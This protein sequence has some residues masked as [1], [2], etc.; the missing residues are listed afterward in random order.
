MGL[1]DFF[2]AK[3]GSTAEAQERALMR[4]AERV[5]DKRAMSP[6]RFASI[7][8]L[9]RLGTEESWRAL[10][11]R[12]D[13][14]VDPSITDREEKQFIF[15]HITEARD[16][17]VDPVREFLPK[18]TSVVWP[19]KILKALVSREELVTALLALLKGEDT[20]Y[21]KNPERKKQAIVFLEDEP[22]P[23]VP[24]ALLPFLEDVSEDIRFHCVRTLTAQGDP[25]VTSAMTALLLRDESMRIRTTVV[26][27]LVERSWP[28]P[29]D[30][31]AKLGP[32]LSRLPNGPFTINPEG[33]V[34]RSAPW[35]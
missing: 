26:D 15:E 35:R 25:S 30:D 29:M 9:C 5:L 2:K 28:L 27:G 11:P 19:I 4:H 12:F 21:Q 34:A 1:F 24:P 23:R 3:G 7:E 22:D 18:A 14:T 13:F 32:L 20:D 6:D 10:L 33:L 17:A 31:R 16:T 8:Y